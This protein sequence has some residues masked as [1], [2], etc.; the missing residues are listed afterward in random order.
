MITTTG[1]GTA[2]AAI[3]LL[4]LLYFLCVNSSYLALILLAARDAAHQHRRSAFGGYEDLYTNPLAPGISVIMPAHDEGVGIVDSV[5]AMLSLNYPSFEVVVVDDGS[6]DDT[7]ERLR[8]EHDLVPVPRVVPDE[9]P[10][11][12]EVISTHVPAAGTAPLL[13]VRKHNGGRADAVNVGV[14]FARNPLVC[15]VDADSLLDPDALLAVARPF[16]DDPWRVV[17]TGGAIRIANGCQVVA[18][19]VVEARMPARW[20][21]RLQV[22]EYLRAFLLGRTGWSR[23]GGLLI[24]SG[25]FGLFRRDLVVEIGGLDTTTIGEDAELVL[26]LHRHLRDRRRDYRIVFVSEPASWTEAPATLAV[27]GRQRRRWQRGLA[28]LL[29]KH[30]AMIGRPRYGRVGM[31]TL[32][33]YILFELAA[34]VMELGGLLLIPLALFVGVVSPAFVLAFVLVSYGY[35]V[36][37]TFAALVVEEYAFRRYTRWR[38]LAVAGGAALLENIGYRQLLAWWGLRGI[39]SALRGGER[40]WG[41]MTRQGF[42]TGPPAPPSTPP[43]PPSTPSSTPSSVPLSKPSSTSSSMPRSAGDREP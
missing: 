26:R 28:E 37:V 22:V 31:I 5:Q 32:P 41:V 9:L 30:R 6:T 10:V 24:I 35:A 3:D 29:W 21:P 39:G 17:A 11:C 36:L 27:L 38:D 33:Y 13:V 14:A 20:L 40:V 34:P 43:V 2:L 19:R 25:A 23:L 1:L 15:M 7:F 4:L 18:G 42:Q 12:G 8:A 16:S